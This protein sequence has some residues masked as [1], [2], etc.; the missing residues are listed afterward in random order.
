MYLSSC[1]QK[2]VMSEMG[3]GDL[4]PAALGTVVAWTGSLEQRGAPDS[5]DVVGTA[6][7]PIHGPFPVDCPP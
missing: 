1:I 5:R 4:N 2:E 3:S 6:L 7:A